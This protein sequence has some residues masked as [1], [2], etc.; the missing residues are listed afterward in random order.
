[1]CVSSA[2]AQPLVF[3]GEEVPLKRQAQKWKSAQVRLP[4]LLMCQ[5]AANDARSL[6][7]VTDALQ[8][9]LEEARNAL[10]EEALA[11]YPEVR[12]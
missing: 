6:S 3:Q 10:A 8:A 2:N 5:A 1:M 4:W 11:Y 12:L 9:R 7:S